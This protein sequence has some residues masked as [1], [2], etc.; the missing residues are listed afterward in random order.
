[1][2]YGQLDS[3]ILFDE[4][5]IS[6]NRTNLQDENTKDRIGFGLGVYHTFIPEKRLNLIF[7]FEFNRT[8]Q[9][10]KS[11]YEGH[12]ASS[13]N[14][15]YNINSIS[16][17]LKGRLN[18]GKKSKIFFE[19]GGFVDLNI[20][21]KRKGLMHIYGP[22]QNNQINFSEY[23]INERVNVNSLNYG[24]SFGIGTKIPFWKNGIIIRTDYKFGLNTLYSYM[25]N[26]Y[27]RYIRLMIGI[28]L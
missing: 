23:E 6:I 25:N 27:N 15:I 16:I 18:L 12:F 7:G 10:K 28:K 3:S 26:I 21:A 20:G 24:F 19:A 13:S 5:L 2:S 17:P 8:S 4:I 22:G 11:M 1:M 9:Y 14:L